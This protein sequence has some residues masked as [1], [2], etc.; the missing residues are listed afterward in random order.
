MVF[1][2]GLIEKADS[3]DEV[4][5][6]LAHE[7]GHVAYR[8][9]EAAIVRVFGLQMLLSVFT[10][11]QGAETI[12][13]L[14]GVLAVLRYN[15]AAEY[16]A[17]AFAVKSLTAANVDPMGL[18]TFFARMQ[19]MKTA[20]KAGKQNEDGSSLRKRIEPLTDL[21]ATHPGTGDRIAT[22]KPLSGGTRPA[23]LSE[24]EWTALRKICG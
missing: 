2:A 5:G 22:I 1:A 10:T 8:H 3:A 23:I 19:K 11:G 7:L 21:F 9:P 12:T 15:R 20:A 13:S 17:D 16:Q 6:V 4:A 18:Q 14:A 24:A